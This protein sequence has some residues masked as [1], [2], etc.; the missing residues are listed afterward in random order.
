MEIKTKLRGNLSAALD[1]IV[2]AA[3]ESALRSAGVAG[4]RV[5]QAEAKE[6]VPKDTR[7]IERNIIIK[8]AE[9]KSDSNKRQTYLVTVRTGKN[10]VA[11]DAY[12]WRWVEDGHKIVLRKP[13]AV[14][15]KEHR[16][17]M[18]VEYGTSKVGARPFIRPAFRNM[19]KKA[20]DA[21]RDRLREK[22]KES[23]GGGK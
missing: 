2:A 5:F 6:L 11:G 22:I 10:N 1:R 20:L 15:W 18:E 17:A 21:M 3:G 13:D 7:T 12:Y 14:T 16:K 19:K 23:L 4:A 9:E 8:R